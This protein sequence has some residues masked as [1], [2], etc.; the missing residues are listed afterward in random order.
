MR[1]PTEE[2]DARLHPSDAQRASVIALE[3]ASARAA[4]ALK[5]SCQS[6]TAV[7]P[8][9]RLAAVRKR[10]ET[11]LEAVKSVRT[12]LDDL[13]GKL[14][15]EQKAQFEQIGPQR[16]AVAARSDALPGYGRGSRW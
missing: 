3:A 10:L 11:M 13:Y 15:D 14:S 2:I 16:A 1:W 5:S 8:P 6:E 4:D 9:A 12:A 7:T